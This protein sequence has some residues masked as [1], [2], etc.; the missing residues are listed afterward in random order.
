MFSPIAVSFARNTW[1]KSTSMA[2]AEPSRVSYMSAGVLRSEQ[3]VILIGRDLFSVRV[4]IS[5]TPEVALFW[6]WL[7]WFFSPNKKVSPSS[8]GGGE[9]GPLHLGSAL[10]QRASGKLGS[11]TNVPAVRRMFLRKMK[12]RCYGRS[13]PP[14]KRRR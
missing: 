12:G 1:T 4:F 13:D 9:L 14:D 11:P 8:Q 10:G 6:S 7:S 2:R 5:G 3:F